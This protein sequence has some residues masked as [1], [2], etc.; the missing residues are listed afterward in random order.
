MSYQNS[1]KDR[2]KRILNQ[3][4]ETD[5]DNI[6]RNELNEMLLNEYLDREPIFDIA[7]VESTS[8]G[9]TR[10]SFTQNGK[11]YY[12]LA[13][14]Y[15]RDGGHLNDLGKKV[16]AEQLLIFLARLSEHK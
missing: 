13:D 4:I 6:K 10:T 1:L 9:G 16:V 12:V 3:T 7:A 5:L 8:P 14:D 15:S 2:I 11:K